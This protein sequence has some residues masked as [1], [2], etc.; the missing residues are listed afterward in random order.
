MCEG[1]SGSQGTCCTGSYCFKAQ[2]DWAQGRCRRGLSG[3]DV[4]P[5][6]HGT[7][8]EAAAEGPSS[9]PLVNGG[10]AERPD[11][12]P[13]EMNEEAW[14]SSGSNQPEAGSG[15]AAG[16]AGGEEGSSAAPADQPEGSESNETGSG[17]S[18]SWGEIETTSQGSTGNDVDETGAV[19]SD[20]SDNPDVG[21]E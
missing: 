17:S 21:F 8:E 12:Q 20:N 10:P 1:D 2:S 19:S 14:G 7:D 6:P 5:K 9:G 16:E 4:I 3:K 13:D 18:G 15:P 11:T